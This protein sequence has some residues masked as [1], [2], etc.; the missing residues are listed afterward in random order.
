MLNITE[1]DSWF[2]KLVYAKN[3]SH[4][5]GEADRIQAH[6]ALAIAVEIIARNPKSTITG[7]F[8]TAE[9]M[10]NHTLEKQTTTAI[11]KAFDKAIRSAS[12]SLGKES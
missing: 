5:D 2:Y 1:I 4:D 11:K 12:P 8:H 3:N 9:A 6:I 7:A 10:I